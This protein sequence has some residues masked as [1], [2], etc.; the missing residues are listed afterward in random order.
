MVVFGGFIGTN[1]DSLLG[2]TLQQKGLLSNNGVNL[3]ATLAGAIVSVGIY[4]ALI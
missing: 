2:A 1:I 4:L 3:V